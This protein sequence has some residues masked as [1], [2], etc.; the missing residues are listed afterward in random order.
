MLTALRPARAS[1][2]AR[3]RSRITRT[4]RARTRRT[5][6][7]PVGAPPGD[8]VVF[9]VAGG[10]M[11]AVFDNPEAAGIMA[12][13]MTGANLEPVTLRLTPA[14]WEQAHAVLRAE[15]PHITVTDTR[16]GRVDG[17]S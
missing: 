15:Q 3:H 1:L 4:R 16:P 17:A 6:Q 11:V 2:L 7:R 14:Q 5:V 13:T 9:V 10:D 12:V 8:A